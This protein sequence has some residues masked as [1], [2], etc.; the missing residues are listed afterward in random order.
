MDRFQLRRDSLERWESLNPMLLEGEIGLVLD[1]KSFKIGDGIHNWNDLDYSSNP[2]IL[3]E[4]GD[5]ESA[6]ISQKKISSVINSGFLY[7]GWIIPTDNLNTDTFENVY[8]LPSQVGVYTNILGSNGQPLDRKEG[9]NIFFS[10]RKEW[11]YWIKSDRYIQM[12]TPDKDIQIY[13]LDINQ[14]LA[15]GYYT[16][17]TA[18]NAVPVSIRKK[19]LQINFRVSRTQINSYIY[20]L[21]TTTSFN[22]IQFWRPM[23]LNTLDISDFPVQAG[24]ISAL[25]G[26][27]VTSTTLMRNQYSVQL[28]DRKKIRLTIPV[29]KA[30]DPEK[31]YA[32]Y[33]AN[34]NYISGVKFSD[35]ETRADKSWYK[36]I[37]I[38]V[39]DGAYAFKTS[40][41]T[42]AYRNSNNIQQPFL[43]QLLNPY[44]LNTTPE[45]SSMHLLGD[46]SSFVPYMDYTGD[47]EA[48]LAAWDVGKLYSEYEALRTNYPERVS[49]NLLGY[50]STASGTADT[51]L[52]IFEY[53]I[54]PLPK[55]AFPFEEYPIPMIDNNP[56]IL[57]V[58]G[59]HGIE[60]SA[61]TATLNFIQLLLA[62]DD[63]VLDSIGSNCIIKVIPCVNPWGYNNNQRNNARDVNINR[64]FAYNWTNQ[65]G[66]NTANKGTAPYS[67]LET[68]VVKNWIASNKT[69]IMYLDIHDSLV[70]SSP[71]N[72]TFLYCYDDKMK[73]LYSSYLR[74]ASSKAIKKYPF[75]A[76]QIIGFLGYTKLSYSMS[77]A[78]YIN[79]IPYAA[80]VEVNRYLF[81]KTC[82]KEQIEIQTS[83]IANI[84]AS[85]IKDSNIE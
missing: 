17:Q 84:M 54:K 40:Y 35:I 42:D 59:V 14:P 76:K 53:I 6:L 56:L 46:F 8:A 68:Q 19:G 60:K 72:A 83:Q 10:Y 69:A 12:I 38:D 66:G 74:L 3:Q 49:R 71:Q 9:E 75:T 7:Y 22:I 64:N 48:A 34:Y 33:D 70:T 15:S 28:W 1:T 13:D 50:G 65:T 4:L 31:G 63:P 2:T 45:S 29:F 55:N 78:Y 43:L 52:P 73:S 37:E 27:N 26:D 61:S 36:I 82:G 25:T 47:V 30:N 21:D 57:M 5:S 16:L 67:E 32:F 80:T 18:I 77:E 81:N 24:S 41:W 62:G 39:P 51:S 85:I 11:G 23:N 79:D 44:G 58:T 20:V